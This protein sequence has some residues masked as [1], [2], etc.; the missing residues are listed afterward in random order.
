M[1]GRPPAKMLAALNN[2]E[3]QRNSLWKTGSNFSIFAAG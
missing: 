1:S 3:N 2:P